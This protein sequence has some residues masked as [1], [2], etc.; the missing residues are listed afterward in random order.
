[1]RKLVSGAPGYVDQMIQAIN[2]KAVFAKGNE[3][4]YLAELLKRILDTMREGKM[5]Y[6]EEAEGMMLA[7][8]SEIARK[9]IAFF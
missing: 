9:N 7:F 5:L 8:L 2:Q 1:M 3:M 6:L 4:P